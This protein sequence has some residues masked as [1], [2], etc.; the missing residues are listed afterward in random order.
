MTAG[1]RV[2]VRGKLSSAFQTLDTGK[3]VTRSLVKGSTLY[4][5]ENE[6]AS[7]PMGDGSTKGDQNRVD[8]L[9]HIASDIIQK[10][11]HSSFAVSTHF[12][13]V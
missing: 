7:S 8:L 9:A 10:D 3:M 2:C 6:S 4:V 1:Q 11:N 13:Q 5:L 12:K